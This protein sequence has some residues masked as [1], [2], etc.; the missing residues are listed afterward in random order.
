MIKT[1]TGALRAINACRSHDAL[2]EL[3]HRLNQVAWNDGGQIRNA[4]AAR[5]TYFLEPE[6]R[7]RRLYTVRFVACG[8]GTTRET[9]VLAP[10]RGLATDRACAKLYG[11]KAFWWADSGLPGY[12][13][14][15]V[16]QPE[17][18]ASR[19]ITGRMHLEVELSGGRR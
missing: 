9:R 12:G 6:S 10:T 3:S 7:P 15:C 1:I 18:N 8:E 19:C 4:I 14:V 13:Q 11:R 5:E 17:V 16:P 2:V